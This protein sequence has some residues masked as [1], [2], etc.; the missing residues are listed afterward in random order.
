VANGQLAMMELAQ[1]RLCCSYPLQGR[2]CGTNLVKIFLF[3]N[4]REESDE[5]SLFECA[6]DSL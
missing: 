3:T 2:E 4:L 6:V 1:L 5:L